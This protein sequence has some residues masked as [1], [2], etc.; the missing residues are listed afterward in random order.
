MSVLFRLLIFFGAAFLLTG[1]AKCDDANRDPQVSIEQMKQE[2]RAAETRAVRFLP[3]A[4]VAKTDQ[5]QQGSFLACSM[6][7]SW[8]GNTKATL[9]EGAD[10]ERA[11]RR[12]AEA[13][14]QAGFE[15]KQDRMLRGGLRFKLQST[16]GVRLLI[17]VVDRGKIID[18]NSFSPCTALPRDFQ[19]PE[20][21]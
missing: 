3:E 6:G 11:Q 12:I 21:Y 4:D 8:S 14:Q 19:S 5:L 7:Y 16:Q 17:T 2:S 20:V 15:V 18:I 13:A 10:A 1:C 9:V